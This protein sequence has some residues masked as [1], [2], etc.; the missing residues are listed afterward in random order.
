MSPRRFERPPATE[1]EQYQREHYLIDSEKRDTG[2][3]FK[4]RSAHWYGFLAM[5]G[6]AEKAQALALASELIDTLERIMPAMEPAPAT[7]E[8]NGHEVASLASA[9]AAPAKAKRKV[10]K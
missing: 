3:G 8:G 4:L 6:F 9:I 7:K 2:Y 5:G 10:R 1:V